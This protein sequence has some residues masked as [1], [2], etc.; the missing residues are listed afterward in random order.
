M[1]PLLLESTFPTMPPQAEAVRQ[2]IDI[3][4]EMP[5]NYAPLTQFEAELCWVMH[6]I[7]NGDIIDAA[8][9]IDTLNF[10]EKIEDK[11]AILRAWLWLA[12]MTIYIERAD[13]TMGIS[14]AENCLKIVA[15]IDRKKGDDFLAILTGVLYNLAVIHNSSLE[16]SRA[17]K[18][19]TKAQ[20]LL[21]RLV[22]KDP[23]RFQSML[24]RSIEASTVIIKSKVSQMNVFA[25]YQAQTELYT[26]MVNNGSVE[27]M[28][29]L[30]ESLKNEGDIMLQVGNSRD[31]VK[32][33]TKALRYQK[34]VSDRM[35]M[36][37]LIL[38]ISLTKALM[39][40]LNRRAAA[41]Q[42]LNSL[43]PLA[44]S[45]NAT[46]QVNEIDELLKNKSKTFSI[47]TILKGIF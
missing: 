30:V 20:K 18:E 24:L 35:G 34:R 8:H 12:R 40:L 19:L 27:A 21:E 25:H 11:P 10:S 43:L 41:E 23:K 9:A 2:H 32:Y 7:L 42:L 5:E 44:R 13:L 15:D 14:S 38:S 16:N 29:D 45:L 37:E 6:L 47:M 4:K 22:K 1:K 17:A 36:R 3:Y 26:D 39:R 31:A 28:S 33:F 46:A